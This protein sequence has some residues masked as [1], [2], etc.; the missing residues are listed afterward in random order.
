MV[1]I[2][3]SQANNG[4]FK[5]NQM[6][7]L[8]YAG[9][10]A[11]EPEWAFPSHKHDE[12]C[13]IIYL[14]EGEGN[15][16]IN[17]RPYLAKKGDILIYNRGILHDEKSNPQNPLKT[18]FCGVGNL[19]IE[20]LEEGQLVADS[21]SPVIHADKYSYKIENYLSNIF[22]ECS[23]QVLG[24]ETVCQHLLVSLIILVL[25][26]ASVKDESVNNNPESLGF[27]IKE[28][29][30]KNYTRDLSLEDIANHV[31]LSPYYISH[32]FKKELGLS[33][34]N[35]L[36]NRR[37]GEAKKLL[38]TTGLTVEEI[39]SRVGYENVNYF[40]MLFKKIAGISPGKFRQDNKK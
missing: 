13:E 33:T 25:R 38:L 2:A 11:D 32:I 10:I 16:I 15:F 40:S 30:D 3:L 23:S 12:L 37:I 34:I 26:I 21:V 6:P 39:S 8:L 9:Q 19:F 28:Y 24:Y 36:I 35:Y 29:I 31:Y 17:N 5:N 7:I 1:Q 4:I 14:S 20:G 27:Q 22:E 18:Y